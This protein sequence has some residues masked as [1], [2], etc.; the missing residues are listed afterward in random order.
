MMIKTASFLAVM[1]SVTSPVLSMTLNEASASQSSNDE[2]GS[3]TTLTDMDELM[4][5]LPKVK[6][7]KHF[8][9]NSLFKRKNVAEAER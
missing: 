4:K 1:L 5:H 7:F 2:T 8:H 9:W 3:N 6:P